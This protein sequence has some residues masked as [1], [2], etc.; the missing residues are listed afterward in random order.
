LISEQKAIKKAAMMKVVRS[1]VYEKKL[2]GFFKLLKKK[3]LTRYY[4][5][6]I[7][8]TISFQFFFT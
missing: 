1:E 7:S 4:C 2:K 8:G 5:E 6:S 3:F